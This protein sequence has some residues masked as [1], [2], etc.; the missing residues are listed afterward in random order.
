MLLLAAILV[1]TGA[2][3]TTLAKRVA[4][5]V[6]PP[7][8]VGGVEYSAPSEA[9]G[10]VIATDKASGKELWRERIY[11]VKIDPELEKDVQDVFISALKEEKGLLLITNEKGARFSLDPKTRKVAKLDK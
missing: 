3:G 9:M 8:T 6:V 7:V 10:F 4:P 2:L 5:P 11:A 1:F